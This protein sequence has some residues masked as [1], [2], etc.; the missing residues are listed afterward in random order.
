LTTPMLC[1]SAFFVC[2]VPRSGST[3]LCDLLQASSVAGNPIEYGV[4]E[5]EHTWRHTHGF[6][7]HR[8]YFLHYAHRLS[9]TGNGVFSAKLMF[10]QMISFVE[11]L[12]RYK[13]INAG[14]MVET[15]DLAFG[16]PRYVRVLRRDK[17]RQAISLAR[18]EQTGAWA[19]PQ[20][21]GGRSEYDPARLD[22]TLVLLLRLESSWNEALAEIAPSR[23][24]TLYYED[25]VENMEGT[26]SSLL[27]WLQIADHPKPFRPP[28]MERQ[29]DATTEEWLAMWRKH[30]LLAG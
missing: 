8:N 28:S 10:R 15:L 1:K 25:I 11:D 3:L 20:A 7:D 16:Q 29:S 21:A 23:K 18:A 14:G 6:S 24:L 2:A 17:E 5:N 13:S 4:E 30:K 19:S 22:H 12:K 27:A 26:I 9:L